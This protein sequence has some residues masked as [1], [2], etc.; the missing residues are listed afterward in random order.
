V[1]LPA[2]DSRSAICS[3]AGPSSFPSLDSA[4]SVTPP[5]LQGSRSSSRIRRPCSSPAI[6]S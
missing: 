1:A 4:I 5:P 2:S 3:S 6:S